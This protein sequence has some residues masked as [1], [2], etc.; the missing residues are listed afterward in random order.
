MNNNEIN[1]KLKP[2]IINGSESLIHQF[3]EAHYV[4]INNVTIVFNEI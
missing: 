2:K 1:N 4:F 3:Q